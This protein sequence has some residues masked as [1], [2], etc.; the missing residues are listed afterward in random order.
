MLNRFVQLPAIVPGTFHAPPP[1][2]NPDISQRLIGSPANREGFR[3]ISH[4]TRHEP[5]G[6]AIARGREYVSKPSGRQTSHFYSRIL[7]QQLHILPTVFAH[8]PMQR[9]YVESDVS[10]VAAPVPQESQHVALQFLRPRFSKPVQKAVQPPVI[11]SAPC[12]E[13][14]Y[15]LRNDLGDFRLL[16]VDRCEQGFFLL[17]EAPVL[18]EQPSDLLRIPRAERAKILSNPRVELP[19]HQSP[20]PADDN[21]TDLLP[22]ASS[23]CPARRCSEPQSA[24]R[25][26]I[27][28]A[29]AAWRVADG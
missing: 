28:R 21:C 24:R 7:F 14:E 20:D 17:K 9:Q 22:P 18:P 15:L 6:L 5:A 29:V 23:P 25:L 26:S 16:E 10:H 27:Q 8:S 4:D 13:P 2:R 11:E 12:K 3:F 1:P 19:H